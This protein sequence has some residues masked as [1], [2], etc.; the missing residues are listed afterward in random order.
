MNR[1]QNK[2]KANASR[3]K[4]GKKMK[5]SGGNTGARKKNTAN[6]LATF[7]V[8]Q[9]RTTT[10]SRPANIGAITTLGSGFRLGAAAAHEDFPHGGIRLGGVFGPYSNS[11]AANQL[12]M[13]RNSVTAAVTLA[14]PNRS[15]VTSS[16]NHFAISPTAL[17]NATYAPVWNMF[18]YDANGINAVSAIS[19]YF[20]KFRFRRLAIRYNGTA[21][22]NTSDQLSISYTPDI[23]QAQSLSGFATFADASYEQN[24]RFPVWT[25][26]ICVDLIK[27]E[28]PSKDDELHYC[29][30]AGDTVS[31][32][33]VGYEATAHQYFQG[34]ACI[35]INPSVG[36]TSSPKGTFQW[37]FELDLYGFKLQNSANVSFW[38]R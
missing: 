4:T 26:E 12:D 31:S 5:N 38:T 15:S 32:A 24:A 23:I 16:Y 9:S 29:T 7:G 13:L 8:T 21:S 37:E 10:I 19:Q 6:T 20:T 35:L 17:S 3:R 22:T 11:S 1:S 28:R 25:P 34:A 14:I 2:K 36:T 18:G 27:P 30:A 33:S